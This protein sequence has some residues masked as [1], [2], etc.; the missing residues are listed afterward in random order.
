MGNPLEEQ[1]EPT[2]VTLADQR[3]GEALDL[4]CGNG[5][6]TLY[7]AKHGFR[8]TAVDTDGNALETLL[9]RA[10]QMNVKQRVKVREASVL[11]PIDGDWDA[12]VVC[13]VLHHMNRDEANTLL[14]RVQAH[15]KPNGMNAIIAWTGSGEMADNIRKGRPDAY[16]L[17]RE[18]LLDRYRLWRRVVLGTRRESGTMVQTGLYQKPR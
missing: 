3:E 1:V 15:T 2:V 5:R 12:I 13:F 16:F 17:D 11:E 18:T 8:V 9:Q 6:N 4:G 7:L 10:N 14:T